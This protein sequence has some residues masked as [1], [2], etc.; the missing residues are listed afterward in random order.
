MKIMRRK[1]AEL[2]YGVEMQSGQPEEGD[3][4]KLENIIGI[5][6]QRKL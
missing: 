2:S 1:T 3:G 5:E 6:G 4:E